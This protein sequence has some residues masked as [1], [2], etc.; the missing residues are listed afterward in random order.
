MKE[1]KKT[2]C[3]CRGLEGVKFYFTLV[4]AKTLTSLRENLTSDLEI[5]AL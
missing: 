5:F 4:M 3:A 1:L 2:I